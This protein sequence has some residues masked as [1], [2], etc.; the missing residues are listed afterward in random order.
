MSLTL[1]L[2]QLDAFATRPFAGNPAAV[3]PLPRWL[4]NT[5]LQAIAAENNLSET[6]FVVAREAYWELRWFTPAVEVDLCGHATLATAYALFH[7]GYAEGDNIR[8]T[9]R[10]GNLTVSR[11]DDGQLTLD[12]PAT[13]PQPTNAPADLA[14]ALGNAPTAV[15]RTPYDFMAVYPDEAAVRALTPDF[16]ALAGLGVRGVIVTAPGAADEVDLVSRYFA[17]GAGIDEDPVTG[18]AHCALAAYWA[19]TLGHDDLAAHQVSARGGVLRCRVR[20]DR[21][22]ITGQVQPY[23]VGEIRIPDGA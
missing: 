21:V 1:P 2:Y 16:R 22:L 23:L 18:S 11:E 10:G 12:F 19:H 13:P 9:S 14:E 5:L 7:Y 20:G 4:P 17:P 8:F 15:F 6:A 3:C